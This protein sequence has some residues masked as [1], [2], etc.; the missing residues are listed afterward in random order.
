M[1]VCFCSLACRDIYG[2]LFRLKKVILD[3]FLRG[4]FFKDTWNILNVWNVTKHNLNLGRLK[5]NVTKF[6]NIL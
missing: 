5:N 3:F 2:D 1:I 4:E 6:Y